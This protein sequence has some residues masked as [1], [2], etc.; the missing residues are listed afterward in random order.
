MPTFY[1]ICEPN[2]HTHTHLSAD[3]KRH[4]SARKGGGSHS[5]KFT[6]PFLNADAR[7]AG[8]LVRIRHR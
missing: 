5:G 1:S 3:A 2:A 6:F 8:P 7:D 4:G